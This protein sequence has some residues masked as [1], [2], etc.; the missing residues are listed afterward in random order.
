MTGIKPVKALKVRWEA[1][2]AGTGNVAG[3]YKADVRKK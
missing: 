2:G 3:N 1:E